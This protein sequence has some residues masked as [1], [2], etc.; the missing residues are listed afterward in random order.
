MF[1][2]VD[3]VRDV[4]VKRLYVANTDHLSICSSFEVTGTLP[5]TPPPPTPLLPRGK[6]KRDPIPDLP[7]PRLTS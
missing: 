5:A 2:M 3:Y 6:K 4:I 1:T 7:L